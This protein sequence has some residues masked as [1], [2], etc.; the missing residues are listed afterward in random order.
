M[1][2]WQKEWENKPE[3]EWPVVIG[4]GLKVIMIHRLTAWEQRYIPGTLFFES[5]DKNGEKIGGLKIQVE[6]ESDPNGNIYDHQD[7]WGRVGVTKG[8]LGYAEYVHLQKP[9]IYIV[10][11][12]EDGDNLAIGNLR[13]DLGNEYPTPPGSNRPASYVPTC[14]PGI[15]SYRIIIQELDQ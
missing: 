5:L 7:V 13:T 2:E 11:F 6:T 15:Y 1:E 12:G 9:T 14:R 3:D 4:S 8:R 10:R